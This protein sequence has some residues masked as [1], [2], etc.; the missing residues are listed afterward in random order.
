MAIFLIRRLLS[1]LPAGRRNRALR[2]VLAKPVEADQTRLLER[3]VL[4]AQDVEPAGIARKVV[5]HIDGEV[6]P[7]RDECARKVAV[8]DNDNVLC[9]AVAVLAAHALRG[10][11]RWLSSNVS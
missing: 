2:P 7:P 3:V 6:A 8:R 4:V 9:R 11:R 5:A 1:I 10:G